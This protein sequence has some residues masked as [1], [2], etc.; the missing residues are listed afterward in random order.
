M[1]QKD[2]ADVARKVA[3]LLPGILVEHWRQLVK[4]HLADNPISAHELAKL[5][6]ARGPGE[7]QSVETDPSICYGTTVL[8]TLITQQYILYLQLGDGD[9]L[10]VSDEGEVGRPLAGDPKLIANETT[11]LCLPTAARDFRFGLEP[12]AD[13]PALI[14]LSTDGYANSFVNDAAF[15]KVGSDILQII[16]KEGVKT[17][18]DNLER[19]LSE[20]S[21]FGSGDD[22]TVGLV[23]RDRSETDWLATA[24]RNSA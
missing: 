12:I 22:I 9:I 7:R 13:K 17:V 5:E 18:S 20:A 21:K 1:M 14:M 19:W 4:E 16:R 11:S 6:E 3:E 2:F 23:Y 15:R 24:T 8:A 10:C